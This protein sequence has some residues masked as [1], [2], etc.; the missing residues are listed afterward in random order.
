M[1]ARQL[2]LLFNIVRVHI[3]ASNGS[4]DLIVCVKVTEVMV[5]DPF[6]KSCPRKKKIPIANPF[7]HNSE[8]DSKI[9]CLL[10]KNSTRKLVA[11]PIAN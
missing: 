7:L 10:F 3:K 4:K 6:V 5:R 8:E 9:V 11:A 1:T 2:I